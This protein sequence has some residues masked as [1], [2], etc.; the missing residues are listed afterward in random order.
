MKRK[1]SL[2]VEVLAKTEETANLKCKALEAEIQKYRTDTQ[3]I[4]DYYIEEFTTLKE[5]A[6]EREQVIAK[7]ARSIKHLIEDETLLYEKR[8]IMNN[9]ILGLKKELSLIKTIK[10]IGY[11]ELTP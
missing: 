4:I 9:E 6:H 8:T 10:N 1:S 5:A 2:F 7:Q 11:I 3:Q